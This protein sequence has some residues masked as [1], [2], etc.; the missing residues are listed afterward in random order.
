MAL[1]SPSLRSTSATSNNKILITAM[2]NRRAACGRAPVARLYRARG[3]P[4]LADH[5]LRIARSFRAA[6]SILILANIGLAGLI[7]ITP[8][9]SCVIAPGHIRPEL[10]HAYLATLDCLASRAYRFVTD[11]AAGPQAS[12]LALY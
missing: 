4:V 2:R 5:Y 3:F 10:G 11:S 7:W 12:D 1:A 8:Q 9:Q 6:F